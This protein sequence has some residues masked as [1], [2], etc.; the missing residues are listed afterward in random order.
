MEKTST[1]KSHDFTNDH[2]ILQ[3]YF[4]S[5]LYP[6]CTPLWHYKNIL[7]AIGPVSDQ[8]IILANL[9]KYCWS[10]HSKGSS[11]KRF[12][13]GENCLD[14]VQMQ[15]ERLVKLC[16]PVEVVYVDSPSTCHCSW[17]QHPNT[18]PLA[19]LHSKRRT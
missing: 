2:P 3:H 18:F 19:P 17:G 6:P 16:C 10:N 14:H 9:R 15:I 8:S 11:F 5:P 1:E 7:Q 4:G 13:P 12:G